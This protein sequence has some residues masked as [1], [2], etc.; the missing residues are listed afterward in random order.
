MRG[1]ARRPEGISMTSLNL[2]NHFPLV[3]DHKHKDPDYL[4]KVTVQESSG[5][6]DG[7]TFKVLCSDKCEESMQWQIR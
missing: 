2:R 7:V 3:G 1:H 6:V 4:L 5:N